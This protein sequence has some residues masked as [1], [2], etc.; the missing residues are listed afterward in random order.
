[1]LSPAA[2]CIDS[3]HL[4]ERV[5]R[6]VRPRLDRHVFATKGSSGGYGEP[7]VSRARKSGV[8]AVPLFMIG[9]TTAKEIVYT[10]L[11]ISTP[12]PGYMHFPKEIKRGYDAAY[13][14]QLTAEECTIQWKAGRKVKKFA[15]P[16][17]RRNEALDI[18]CM[19]LAAREL[20]NPD[21]SALAEQAR[22]AEMDFSNDETEKTKTQND[23]QPEET[24]GARQI[25]EKIAGPQPPDAGNNDPGLPLQP[26]FD[27]ATGRI[28]KPEPKTPEAP[29]L[30]AAQVQSA[31]AN[32]YRPADA[33]PPRPRVIIP[34]KNFATSW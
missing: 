19:A 6:F 2:C 1:V 13:F 33:P 12:G 28:A 30:T 23:V 22:Q 15:N 27:P 32:T 21:F 5:Y 29:A 10:R 16:S 14:R 11:Q 7:L 9:T 17:G 18:R 25:L 20:R 34:R 26:T 3:G 4:P 31:P 24:D 8:H